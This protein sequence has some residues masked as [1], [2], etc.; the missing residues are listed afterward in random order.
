MPTLRLIPSQTKEKLQISQR[1][2]SPERKGSP[3]KTHS[4]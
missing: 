2:G 1:A 4:G 3:R